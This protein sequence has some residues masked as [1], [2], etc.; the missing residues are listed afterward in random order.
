MQEVCIARKSGNCIVLTVIDPLLSEIQS[1]VLG[2]QKVLVPT[3]HHEYQE[4]QICR[5]VLSIEM[6]YNLFFHPESLELEVLNSLVIRV[7]CSARP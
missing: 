2:T 7:L 4:Y 6:T 5:I 3:D 1:Y